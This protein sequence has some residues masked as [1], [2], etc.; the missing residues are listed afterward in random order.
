[1]HEDWGGRKVFLF[2]NDSNIYVE[3]SNKTKP[4]KTPGTNKQ[5]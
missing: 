5:L 4:P 2:S 1:M 3:N